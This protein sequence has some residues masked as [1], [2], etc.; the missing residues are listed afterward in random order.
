MAY[1][2]VRFRRRQVKVNLGAVSSTTYLVWKSVTYSLLARWGSLSNLNVFGVAKFWL[3]L[4]KLFV[5]LPTTF[6]RKK[7]WFARTPQCIQILGFAQGFSHPF[8]AVEIFSDSLHLEQPWHGHWELCLFVTVVLIFFFAFFFSFKLWRHKVL[9]CEQ[10]FHRTA[11]AS[12]GRGYCGSKKSLGLPWKPKLKIISLK[13]WLSKRHKLFHYCRIIL[14]SGGGGGGESSHCTPLA[15]VSGV[16]GEKGK[17]GSEK[18]SP[19]GR[20]DTQAS[21]PRTGHL[22]LKTS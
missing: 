14:S 20:P 9:V 10:V 13:M 19:L 18:G 4:F 12:Q 21:T 8:E 22:H 16:S 3:Q 5:I 17:D 6:L 1:H 7:V 2:R 15:W 11:S